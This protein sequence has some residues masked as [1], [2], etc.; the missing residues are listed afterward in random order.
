MSIYKDRLAA[1]LRRDWNDGELQPIGYPNFPED[2]GDDFF[3]EYEA[4]EK[5]KK[6]F[7]NGRHGFVWKKKNENEPNHSWDCGIYHEA[8]VDMLCYD[9]NVHDLG[10]DRID[11]TAFWEYIAENKLFYSE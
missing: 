5:V 1:A 11:Y 7:T 4:E 8:A 2:Y 9:V 6:K 10:Q 3:R